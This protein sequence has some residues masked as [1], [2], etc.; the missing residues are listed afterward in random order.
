MVNLSS[1]DSEEESV[2]PR[3]PNSFFIL[4]YVW[5]LGTLPS[6]GFTDIKICQ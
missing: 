1:G 6:V 3:P 5:L 4:T 2:S